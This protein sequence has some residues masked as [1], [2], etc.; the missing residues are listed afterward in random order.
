MSRP[1]VMNG[2]FPDISWF[3]PANTEFRICIFVGTE[4][5]LGSYI[6]VMVTDALGSSNC[7]Y[8]V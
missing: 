5:E 1:I 2:G 6:Y 4:E 7:R 3:I 8:C